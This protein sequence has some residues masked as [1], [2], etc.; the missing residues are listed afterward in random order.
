MRVLAAIALFA[1]WIALS[2]SY[3]PGHLIAG[4]V[5]SI[6]IAWINPVGLARLQGLSLVSAITF[7]PWLFVRILRSS[8]HVSWLIL[9]PSLPISPRLIHHKTKLRSD[10]EL[11]VAG[12]S[13]TLTPGTITVEASPGKLLVHALDEESGADLTGG[14]LEERVSRVFPRQE[15]QP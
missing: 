11:V 3:N 5:F 6:A 8:L 9:R 7:V 13:I 2:A 4:A 10:G 1:L 12:N 15:D 14:A